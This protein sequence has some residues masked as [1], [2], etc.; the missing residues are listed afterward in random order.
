MIK[1]ILLLATIVVTVFL[2]LRAQSTGNLTGQVTDDTTGEEI[3]NATVTLKQ[4]GEIKNGT[5]TGFDG[6]YNIKLIPAGDYEIEVSGLGYKIIVMQNVKIPAGKITI[7]NFKLKADVEMLGEVEVVEYSILL[8]EADKTTSGNTVIERRGHD[9][10]TDI[11]SIEPKV[12]T[13]VELKA[14]VVFSKVEAAEKTSTLSSEPS[15]KSGTLTAGEVNDFAKWQLW[16][17]ILTTTFSSYLNSW[18]FRPLERYIAQL[19]NMKGMPVSNAEVKLINSSGETLW[20]SK[21]DNT[22]KAE[23]WNSFFSLEKSVNISGLRIIFSYDGKSSEIISVKDF[24]QGINVAKIDVECNT[25]KK[26]DLFFIIDATGSMSDEMKYLQVE[27]NDIIDK[28]QQS[29]TD[30]QLR[31]GSLVYRDHGDEYIIR[32]SSLSEDINQTLN[33]LKNQQANGGG[34]Y[35]E[36]VDEALEE[37]IEKENW[38]NDAIAKIVF[39]VLDAPSHTNP[40]VIERLTTQIRLAAQ[41]GIRIVPIACSDIQKDGEYLM[42]TI[43]LATNGTYIFLTDDSG[44]GNVHIKPT[45]DKYEVEKLNPAN[46]R[47]LTQYSKTPDCKSKLW[48]KENKDDTES[49]RFV[50]NPSDENPTEDLSKILINDL[51][52]IY[53][54]PCEELLKIETRKKDISDIYLVDMTGKYLYGYKVKSKNDSFEVNIQNLSTGVYFV[55]VFYKGKWFSQKVIK[56]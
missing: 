11:P 7:Q 54:N 35:P 39:I 18:K 40:E 43:A 10:T 44:V 20:Q 6:F 8:I 29:Q 22:G 50:P 24:S 15:I 51:V 48:A 3:F 23:L 46:V 5:T 55:K 27:L 17:N 45:T 4:N 1:K 12:I 13:P 41:K 16:E 49:E 47:I 52:K 37:V 36:A 31:I 56:I 53:P 38:A 32:K 34:D 2:G 19:T 33:F 26:V 28:T 25:T 30:L 42:R 9:A 21:T 14:D